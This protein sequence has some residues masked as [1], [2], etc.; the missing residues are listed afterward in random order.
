MFP[1]SQKRGSFGAFVWEKRKLGKGAGGGVKP[2]I[3]NSRHSYS[4]SGGGGGGSL[5]ALISVRFPEIQWIRDKGLYIEISGF[6]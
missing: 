6:R 4:E 1:L 3:A 2:I 5:G